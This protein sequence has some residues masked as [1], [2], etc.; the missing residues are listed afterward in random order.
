MLVRA[1]RNLKTSVETLRCRTLDPAVLAESLTLGGLEAGADEPDR[2]RCA[3]AF[4]RAH[5]VAYDDAGA[6][7]GLTA[8]A[9]DVSAGSG[10]VREAVLC[11]LLRPEGGAVRSRLTLNVVPDRA[12]SIE[13]ELPRGRL[14][15]VVRDGTPVTPRVP[16]PGATFSIPLGGTQTGPSRSTVVVASSTSTIDPSAGAERPSRPTFRGYHCRAWLSSGKWR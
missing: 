7:L 6:A 14:E 13:V 15:R 4:R 8:E 2:R 12:T 3:P 5:A 11:D 10:V 1:A 9:L 16:G